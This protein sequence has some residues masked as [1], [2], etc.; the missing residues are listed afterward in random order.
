MRHRHAVLSLKILM[1]MAAVLLG[2]LNFCTKQR[3]HQNIF[4]AASAIGDTKDTSRFR[5]S[6]HSLPKH[7]NTLLHDQP[8]RRSTN[9]QHL[10]PVK[11]F[12]H[13]QGVVIVTKIHGPHQ[14]GLLQQSLCLLHFAYNKKPLYDIV[15]FTAE[16]IESEMV[17]SLRPLVAPAVITVVLDNSGL[18][19]E[20]EALSPPRYQA[21]I[22]RCKNYM[23]NTN[24]ITFASEKALIQ[25]LT[26]FS[27]CGDGRLAY[28]WQAEFR[29][30]HIWQHPALSQYKWMLWIDTDVFCTKPWESDPVVMAIQND[31]VILF[32]NYP[33]GGSRALA[34]PIAQAFGVS[35]CHLR[36]SSVGQLESKLGSKQDAF[37]NGPC[38]STRIEAIHG[39]MHITNMDFYRSPEVLQGIES[40][41]GECF[42]C[43]FPDD[44]MGVTIPAAILAP[45]KAWD[46]RR[47]GA[48]LDVFHNLRL[49]G[50]DREKTMGFKQLWKL[51]KTRQAMKD[52][53]GVCPITEK[54]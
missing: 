41:F 19:Q 47:N 29:S 52:A 2:F 10:A 15:I 8:M 54:M 45:E 44:Q 35:L 14:W 53:R 7:G 3:A 32:D 40:L 33:G 4:D 50:R 1:A 13:H 21:F 38:N 9:D 25:N 48:K 23:E 27:D 49:D 43:R 12:E 34:V 24:N 37:D 22:N 18:Q 46:M 31:L 30:W 36:L 16:P 26:W 5:S 39:F 28:N 6:S 51:K 42:L 17:E 11:E 20:I